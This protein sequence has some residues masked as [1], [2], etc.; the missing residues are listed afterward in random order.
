MAPAHGPGG[1]VA[2]HTL[3][4]VIRT[5]R[6]GHGYD[7]EHLVHREGRLGAAGSFGVP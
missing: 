6:M 2:I 1:T 7:I 3:K 5:R 4:F